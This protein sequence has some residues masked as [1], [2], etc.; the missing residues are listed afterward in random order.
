VGVLVKDGYVFLRQTYA[1]FHTAML[2]GYY[3]RPQGNR[4]S[5][6]AMASTSR[7]PGGPTLRHLNAHFCRISQGVTQ[8][9]SGGQVCATGSSY[10][11]T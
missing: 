4:T 7:D 2:P 8:E 3:Q 5:R 6:R 1:K 9:R 10:G 11:T